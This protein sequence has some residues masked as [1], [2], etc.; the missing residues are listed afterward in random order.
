MVWRSVVYLRGWFD[1]Q[2]D[3]IDRRLCIESAPQFPT[4]LWGVYTA[5]VYLD[6][7]F[8]TANFKTI[9]KKTK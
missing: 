2:P 8:S 7:N 3:A 6:K 9:H 5:C 1:A 4:A